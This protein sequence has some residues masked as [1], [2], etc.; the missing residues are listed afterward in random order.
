MASD[1]SGSVNS[2]KQIFIDNRTVKIIENVM[3][4]LLFLV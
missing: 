2:V 1:K 3:K 4:M